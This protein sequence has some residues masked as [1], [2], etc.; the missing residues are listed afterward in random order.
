MYSIILK[1]HYVSVT[2]FFL[3]YLIKTILLLTSKNEA[4]ASFSKKVKVPEMIISFLFLA[5]GIYLMTQVAEI[6][7]MLIIKITIVLLS[8]PLAIVGYKKSNKALAVLAFVLITAAYGM[9]EMM[10]HKKAVVT[11]TSTNADGSINGQELYEANCTS[12]HGQDGKAKLM[13]ALDL[14][15]TQLSND[16]ISS[17]VLNGRGNMTPINGLTAEQAAAI[18]KYVNENIKGK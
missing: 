13:G 14:S 3:V 9:G 15:I 5:T 6:K 18:S 10:K 8:I 7:P 16:S 17:V 4:L 2:L 1:T 12:C 11:E